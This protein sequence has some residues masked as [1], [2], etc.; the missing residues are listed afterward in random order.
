MNNLQNFKLAKTLRWISLLPYAV[1]GLLAFGLTSATELNYFVKGYLVLLE[2]QAGI[3]LIYFAMAKL[4][5]KSAK[6]AQ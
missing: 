5:N 3:V 2:S 1:F 6:T 4:A